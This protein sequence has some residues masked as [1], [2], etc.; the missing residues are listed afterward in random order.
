MVQAVHVST[1]NWP[2]LETDKGSTLFCNGHAWHKKARSDDAQCFGVMTYTAAQSKGKAYN[3][4]CTRTRS[5]CPAPCG[6]LGH[7][8]VTPV[9][10]CMLLTQLAMDQADQVASLPK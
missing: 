9:K 8:L 10:P 7:L 3:D 4:E 6:T 5:D 1:G 2:G